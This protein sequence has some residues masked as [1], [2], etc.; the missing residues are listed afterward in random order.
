MEWS[1]SPTDEH[2]TLAT[3]ADA[4][5]TDCL[6]TR[7]RQWRARPPSA[8]MAIFWAEKGRLNIFLAL[9]LHARTNERTKRNDFP[10]GRERLPPTFDI[11]IRQAKLDRVKKGG[12][13]WAG[14]LA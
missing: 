6:I 4:R 1:G 2:Q 14:E 5:L 7:G 11:P 12:T 9:I 13:Q 8:A 3:L 10:V